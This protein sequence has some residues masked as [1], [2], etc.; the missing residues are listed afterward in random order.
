MRE[1]IYGSGPADA[2]SESQDNHGGKTRLPSHSTYRTPSVLDYLIGFRAQPGAHHAPSRHATPQASH[3]LTKPA[4]EKQ[5]V[6]AQPIAAHA[7]NAAE[8]ILAMGLIA[9]RLGHV[10]AVF[11]TKFSGQHGDEQAIPPFCSSNP[12]VGHVAYPSIASRTG[13]P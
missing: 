4:H 6:C 3:P 11:F 8:G 9:K 7:M 13:T 2:E 5:H 12:T 1:G 10:V